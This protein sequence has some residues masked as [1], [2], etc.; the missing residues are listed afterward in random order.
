MAIG[1][2]V[3]VKEAN[4]R[5]KAFVAFGL[6]SAWPSYA[7]SPSLAPIPKEDYVQLAAC[8]GLIAG[9]QDNIRR[10]LKKAPTD[11]KPKIQLFDVQV[12]DIFLQMATLMKRIQTVSKPRDGKASVTYDMN[13]F[14]TQ[15]PKHDAASIAAYVDQKM[16][17]YKQYCEG[18]QRKW[19]Q[20]YQS[21]KG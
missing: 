10:T 9:L 16:V 4:R 21:S 8:A 2:K 1:R 12:N 14:V 19:T 18:P 5:L 15:K 17:E 20:I 11:S 3:G 6:L 7:E 13:R